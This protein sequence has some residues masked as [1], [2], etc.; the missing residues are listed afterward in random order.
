[1]KEDKRVASGNTR[2]SQNHSEEELKIM[3]RLLNL[4]ATLSE[5]QRISPDECGEKQNSL[6]WQVESSVR[7][8]IIEKTISEVLRLLKTELP[9]NLAGPLLIVLSY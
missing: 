9:Y 8:A 5:R 1:V 6:P 2:I 3:R 7:A 4:L